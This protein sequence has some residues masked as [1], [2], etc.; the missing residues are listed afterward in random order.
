MS[1]RNERYKDTYMYLIYYFMSYFL[2]AISKV[3]PILINIE[4]LEQIATAENNK[5]HLHLLYK[6]GLCVLLSV[7]L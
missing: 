6:E 5:K 2:L 1:D 7:Q 4:L 3:A